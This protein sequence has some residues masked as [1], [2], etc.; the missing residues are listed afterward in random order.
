VIGVDIVAKREVPKASKLKVDVE[1]HKTA[2]KNGHVNLPT[3]PLRN[4]IHGNFLISGVSNTNFL[5]ETERSI[6]LRKN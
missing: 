2:H 6:E 1:G 4:S 5:I 3:N